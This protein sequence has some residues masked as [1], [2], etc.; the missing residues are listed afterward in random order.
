MSTPHERDAAWTWATFVAGVPD[1]NSNGGR[2]NS[3]LWDRLEAHQILVAREAGP[4][5]VGLTLDATVVAA[6]A[7]R[8]GNATLSPT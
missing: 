2:I 1:Y 7:P 3:S 6:A 8:L 4:A 5:L